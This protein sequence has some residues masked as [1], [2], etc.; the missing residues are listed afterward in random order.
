MHG[1]GAG[2]KREQAKADVDAG[3]HTR[4]AIA[5]LLGNRQIG[6]AGTLPVCSW[7][8]SLSA[9]RFMQD[10]DDFIDDLAAQP[11]A[12][13]GHKRMMKRTAAFVVD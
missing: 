3:M 6:F 7:L 8:A 5:P 4:K 13:V 11:L 2:R 12:K 1:C 9:F 10:V